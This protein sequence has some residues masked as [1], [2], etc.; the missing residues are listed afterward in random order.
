EE[1][2]EVDDP[3]EAVLALVDQA[4]ALA[5][6]EPHLP[7]Y[8][9]GDRT[10]VGDEQ[11]Q[12]ALLGPEQ[13]VQLGQLGVAEELGGRRAPAVALAEGPDEAFGAELLRPR[14]EAVE[15]RAR[16]LAL[17]RVDPADRAATL[18]HR[19]EDFELGVGK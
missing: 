16:H 17:A 11:Q 9:V 13:A 3:D 7:E 1:H 4:E 14:D 18:E 10:L 6:V 2:R 15:L 12:V 8:R 5:E 19:L